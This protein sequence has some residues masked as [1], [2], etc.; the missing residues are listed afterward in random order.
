LIGS[1]T[2]LNIKEADL[3]LVALKIKVESE[4]R[5][6]VRKAFKTQITDLERNISDA[7][8]KISD[9]TQKDVLI[10]IDD[11]D[12][13]PPESA[14]QIFVKDAHIITMPEAK[15]I[16]TFPLASYYSA[17]FNEISDK[18]Q[19]VY[20]RLVNL[21]DVNGGYQEDSF[22]A[23]K[24]LVLKRIR[25]NLTEDHAIKEIID[26]SG[27]VVRHLVKFMQDA[28]H[29]AITQEKEKIDNQVAKGVVQEKI[30]EYNRIFDFVK[31]KESVDR[32]MLRKSKNRIPISDVI[33]LLRHR[34]VLEYGEY[35][36]ETWFDAH[37]C[38]KA[39]L[40][41]SV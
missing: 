29:I 41:K 20:I 14:E 18:F 38:L 24:E 3:N 30:N 9:Q 40:K 27:G 36:G 22:N 6:A 25:P 34:F 2:D 31:Y 35:G 17:S 16:F 26:K 23:L 10:I 1:V 5:E 37:P 12:K 11:I 32:I 15:V 19:P 8:S 39:C 33:Y 13:L 4:S 28:C 21:Y 7:C